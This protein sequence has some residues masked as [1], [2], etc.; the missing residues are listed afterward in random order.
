MFVCIS[1]IGCKGAITEND[2]GA[3]STSVVDR[4]YLVFTTVVFDNIYDYKSYERDI[5]D[6]RI[7]YMLSLGIRKHF[8]LQKLIDKRQQYNDSLKEW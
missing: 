3:Y 6:L 5:I 1:I 4:Y 7:E 2:F 8:E